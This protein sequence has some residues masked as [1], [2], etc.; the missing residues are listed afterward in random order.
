MFDMNVSFVSGLQGLS[1]GQNLDGL[2]GCYSLSNPVSVNRVDSGEICNG[3][4]CTASVGEI[5]GGPFVFDEIGDGVPDFIFSGSISVVDANSDNFFW[6]ITDSEGNIIEIPQLPSAVNFDEPGEGNWLI[7]YLAFDGE[8]TGA[9]VG[10]NANDIEGCFDLSNPV[11]A[12]RTITDGCNANGGNLLGGPFI[13]NE[14]GDGI[15]DMIPVGSITVALNIGENF[16]WVVTDSDRVILGL[17]SMPS[18]V[19]FD[20]AGSGTCLIWYL[21]F[22]GTITGLEIGL[23][24]N[25][26]EGCFDLSTSIEVIRTTADVCEANG[27][28]LVGRPFVFNEVGD[29]VPDV[30]PAGSITISNAVGENVAWVVTGSDGVILGL[31][32]TPGDVDFDVAGTG[33]CLIWYLAYH[34]D[35]AGLALGLNANDLNGCFDL[36]NPIEVF[37]NNTDGCSLNGGTLFG[38]PFKFCVADNIPDF[39]PEGAITLNN[40]TGDIFQWIVTDDMGNILGFPFLPSDVDFEGFGAGTC[41]VYH[42]S[43]VDGVS[44][45]TIGSSISELQGCFSLSNPIEVVRNEFGGDCI[46]NLVDCVE[47][48]DM[49]NNPIASKLYETVISI[50]SHGTVSDGAVSFSAGE[51]IELEAGFEVFSG[52]EFHAYIESCIN[53]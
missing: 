37:R 15:P 4:D 50:N 2:L 20:L 7:W 13:F 14:V 35:I 24:A 17:P 51:Y 42:V 6:L 1:V 43:L 28:E 44:G 46:S 38:G 21:A 18:D 11:E 23:N 27:G 41:L 47:T 36:S 49:L 12:I 31:P 3:P 39:I 8:I 40:V 26:L 25:D 48:L 10:L 30:I 19:D 45:L 22:D 33:N 32:L 53:E 16:A 34:G 5:I 9:E 52:N 29:G